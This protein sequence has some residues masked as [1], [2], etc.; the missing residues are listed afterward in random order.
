MEY[1]VDEIRQFTAEEDVKFLRLAFCDIFGSQK[2]ISILPDELDRAFSYG[3]AFD[4]SAVPGFGDEVHSD[5]FLHPASST[6]CMLPWRP[7][8][9]RVARM[10]CHVLRPDGAAFEADC[11]ALLRQAVADAEAL[12]IRFSFGTEMEFYLFRR[13]ENGEA[14]HIP[15]DNAG[16][17]DIAPEDKGENVRRESCL[18]LGADFNY[19]YGDHY[20]SP[21][22]LVNLLVNIVAKGGNLALNISPQPDGRIP[23]EAWESLRGLGVWM[24]MYGEA[25]YGTRI[26]ARTGAETWHLRE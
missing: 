23:V 25:I 2:N 19:A 17:M 24:Q 9:G 12:G 20:K 6:L 11:R 7:D 13:D 16:Y 4:A 10:F 5:L 15:Y 8:H 14:T 1:T 26:C 18:T 22:E 21:R 3:I